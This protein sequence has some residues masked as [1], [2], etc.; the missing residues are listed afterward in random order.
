MLWGD[1]GFKGI[2]G[3]S[4]KIEDALRIGRAL[5]GNGSY[6]VGSDACSS[7]LPIKMAV[8]TGLLSGGSSVGDVGLISS[9][10]LA[11]V[12][13]L[14]NLVGIMVTGSHSPAGF[15]GI[16][17]FDQLGREIST[18]IDLEKNGSHGRVGQLSDLDVLPAYLDNLIAEFQPE[19]EQSIVLDPANSV[20]SIIMPN[21]LRSIGHIVTEINSSLSSIPTRPFEPSAEALRDLSILV[22]RKR[23]DLGIAYNGDGGR[24]VFVD[25]TGQVISGSKILALI[26]KHKQIRSLVTNIASSAVLDSLVPEL[27]RVPVSEASIAKKIMSID[28]ELGG[29]GSGGIIYPDWSLTYDGARTSLELLRIM[30]NSGKTLVELLAELPETVITKKLFSTKEPE[31]IIEKARK[32][33][34]EYELDLTDG[35]KAFVDDGWVLIIAEPSTNKLWILAEGSNKEKAEKLASF[36]KQAAGL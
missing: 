14:E 31:I 18:E 32:R 20:M 25:K 30:E 19:G 13:R 2:F 7:S 11:R 23:A 27:V 22:K 8:E 24:A 10:G 21:L 4:F 34:S 33:L 6:L 3:K 15:V 16:R 29:D 12:C 35:V 5:G 1:S 17:V 28:A 9:P 26:T 36:G